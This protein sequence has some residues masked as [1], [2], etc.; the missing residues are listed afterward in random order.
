MVIGEIVRLTALAFDANGHKMAGAQ[1]R[2]RSSDA[3]IA[4]V[5]G[6]GLV[7]GTGE[8]TAAITAQN[9]SALGSAEVTVGNPDRAVLAALYHSTGGDR[10]A[11]NQG[12]LQDTPLGHWHG[13]GTD[14]QGYVRSLY[15][16]S[17][18]LDGSIPPELGNLTR[19]VLLYLHANRLSG[20]IPSELGNLSK[21]SELYLYDNDLTG[22][23]PSE[24]GKLSNLRRLY[25]NDND[26]TGPIPPELGNLSSLWGLSLSDNDLTGPIPPEL[27]KLSNLVYL[28][29][30][31]SSLT[32]PIPADLGNLDKLVRL[33]LYANDLTGP[34]P[35]EL[36]NL[37]NLVN[38]HLNANDLTGPIPPEL[39]NLSNL[40]TLYLNAN[41]LTGPIPPE[42]GN[43]SNL[44][45]LYLNANDLTGPI[46]SELGNLT[47]LQYASFGYNDLAGPIQSEL[48]QL[49]NLR[50][51]SF[52]RSGLCLPG[53]PAFRHLFNA[54]GTS[55]VASGAL[56]NATDVNALRAL[57]A[58]TD[59]NN[60]TTNTKWNGPPVLADWS[61]VTADSLGRVT[62]LDLGSN[63]LDGAVPA[64]L[65]DLAEATVLLLDD[66][67]NLTGPLSL[68]LTRLSL[69]VFHY[70]DTHVCTPTNAAFRTWLNTIQD[71]RESGIA[72]AHQSDRDVLERL[73]HATD[74]PNWR[75]NTDWLSG[76]PLN[77]WYGVTTNPAGD[78][79]GLRLGY[80]RL[81]GFLPPE[82][83]DLGNLRYLELASNYLAGLVPPELGALDTLQTLGLNWNNLTGP[84]PPELGDL[85]SLQYVNFR[86][87]NLTGSVPPELG[88]LANLQ[89]AN[90]GY[91]D[92]TGPVPYEL[93]NLNRLRYLWLNDN[94]LTGRV[95]RE[96]GKLDALRY[97][98]LNGNRLDG[99]I[100]PQI[101][102]LDNLRRLYL[103]GNRLD[104]PIP[105]Q[106]GN[107]D[108]LRYLYLNGNDLE[109]S[110]PPAFSSLD[111]LRHLQLSYNSKLAGALSTTLT[112]MEGL[113]LLATGDTELC[114]QTGNSSVRAWLDQIPAKRID[115][116]KPSAAYLV[117]A[118]QSRHEHER[119]HMVA[120]EAA[121][122]R[123][124]LVAA[125]KSN[126]HIPDVVAKFYLAGH[127]IHKISIPGKATPIPTA[128]DEGDLSK[129]VNAEVPAKIVKTGLEVV[130]EVDSV[131]ASLGVPRR[132]PATGRMQIPG[133]AVP[134]LKLT[135]I[136]F[137]YDA[138]PDSSIIDTV[139]DMAK[140]PENHELLRETR[141]LLPVETIDATAHLPV[142]IDSR[143]GWAV[144]LAT[145]AIWVNQG[146]G[147]HHYMGM[148]PRFSDVGGVAYLPGWAGASNTNS[149]VIAHELGHNMNLRHAPCGRNI[150]PAGSDPNFPNER[151][152][153][154]SWGYDFRTGQ[155]VPPT[156]PD[157]MSYCG[158]PDGI[159][160]YHFDRS[161][162]HRL[163]LTQ[164]WP[165][166]PAARSLLLWGGTGED[167][168][169]HLEP[170]F[171][172]D[173]PPA[174]PAD[175]G[176]HQLRGLDAA[177][178]ELFSVRFDMPEV[179]DA[180]GRSAF[181]F[182]LPADPR[183]ADALASVTLS[184]PGGSATLDR[185][186]DEPMTILQDPRTGQIRAFLRD[187]ARART[188]ATA[189]NADVLFSRG[190]PGPD[191]WQR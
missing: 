42:L 184:G 21:L 88:G 1:F 172:L 168:R 174:L 102:N 50:L 35:P 54:D 86:Y 75:N 179:A 44:V 145:R 161:R 41:D 154:G 147:D 27:G 178:G 59:G 14:Q 84:V 185:N 129:S 82:L 124:F 70:N 183:W 169:P 79:T 9:G 131:D 71:L 164:P 91:N 46:P 40:V 78:V 49:R 101:G 65:A 20:P 107:L 6:N 119:V 182:A 135:L 134:S 116:C 130:V 155:V 105:P 80:N 16:K 104:G 110:I 170:A 156:R 19:L 18:G 133:S 17:N 139:D 2:W 108:S 48:G 115:S 188:L 175:G 53:I 100:P 72:C 45:T 98:Y 180:D 25:L 57:Y 62:E 142:T 29:L 36:G 26:L 22:P 74:G 67:A 162:R 141:D 63:G 76:K 173:A 125:K 15:L 97:L 117:Q 121:L 4:S 31:R 146:S 171:I 127:E 140:D 158:P 32:G 3:L 159:S 13:V 37:S 122:L 190:I 150:F 186:T 77:A 85:R 120:G 167:G 10:W 68:A 132:I 149:D 106:I 69:Q 87:N 51:L 163:K 138:N 109:G 28:T 143:S 160:G 187:R 39:G 90:F 114:A 73:Y 34:I 136:P 24:L 94:G 38:L 52:H 153:I 83:G 176:D 89:Y 181:A 8:G 152:R 61:G 95:P 166:E 126:V 123:I 111:T 177:G 55:S 137:L 5:D 128:V 96:L 112:A 157:L 165:R 23:I 33:H 99:P 64:D 56:C 148:M 7:R 92:L 103:N 12:W 93:G 58:H 60:W 43:L 151:G 113:N 118:V 191:A 66:N 30:I 144:L 189:L 47:N 81:D 11:N